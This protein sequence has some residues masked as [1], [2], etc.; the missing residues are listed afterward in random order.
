MAR[1][2]WMM[3]LSVCVGLALTGCGAADDAGEELGAGAQGAAL[4]DTGAD[5]P[6]LGSLAQPLVRG[7]S[8]GGAGYTCS[9]LK[10][11]CTG[12]DDCN[13]MFGSGKCGDISSCDTTDPLNPVCECLILKVNQPP[14]R[15]LV[16]APKAVL[17]AP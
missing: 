10:C 13:D 12:D 7:G 17:A 16:A 1:T 2:T 3:A 11:T 5:A 4:E 8:G 14:T 9:G 15:I 6:E